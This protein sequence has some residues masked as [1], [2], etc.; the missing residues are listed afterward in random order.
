MLI[1]YS[2]LFCHHNITRNPIYQAGLL[3]IHSPELSGME[4]KNLF[5]SE[6]SIVDSQAQNSLE[7]SAFASGSGKGEKNQPAWRDMPRQNVLTLHKRNR[8]G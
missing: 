2:D 4:K 6:G 7:R 5:T 1:Q 8:L 3:S